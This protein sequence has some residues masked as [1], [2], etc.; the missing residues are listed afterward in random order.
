MNEA[1][2]LNVYQRMLNIMSEIS[3][4]QKG[5]K[6]V[7]NQ[8]AYV[9]HDQVAAALHN[10]F[11]KH[12]VFAIVDV[13]SHDTKEIQV[14][15]DKVTQ[16][17]TTATLEITYVNVDDTNDRFSAKSF[18]HAVDPSDKGPGKAVSYAVKYNYLKQ[19][20]LN[21]GEDTDQTQ[22]IVTQSDLKRSA[23]MRKYGNT[24]KA[25]T[26]C[27]EKEDTA[28]A[29]EVWFELTDEE[30]KE[31]WIAPSKGGVFDAKTRELMKSKEF[32]QSYYGDSENV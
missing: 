13:L 14:G 18:G 10:L 8:Y 7:N 24:I 9:S 15:R 21:T 20:C 28:G 4:I 11:V 5:A 29:A 3:H 1:K 19:F 6:K 31:I 32:R 26:E 17:F 25:I 22:E 16:V 12:G 30:K 23:L 2:G 27:L